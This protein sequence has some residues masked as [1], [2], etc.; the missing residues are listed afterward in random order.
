MPTT[1][2][3]ALPAAAFALPG[4]RYPIHDEAHARA[5]LRMRSHATPA[6]RKQIEAKVYARYPSLRPQETEKTA[7]RKQ[8]QQQREP[9]GRTLLRMGPAAGAAAGLALRARGVGA[10]GGVRRLV[11]GAA[12]GASIGWLPQVA[13]EG[14]DGAR[15]LR[16]GLEKRATADLVGA[17]LRRM[18]A[19]R[20]GD[21]M[22][23]FHHQAGD[24]AERTVRNTLLKEVPGTKGVNLL[25]KARNE[26]LAGWA[27]KAAKVTVQD[28]ELA[29]AI[30]L[31]LPG[32]DFLGVGIKKGK[33][34]LRKRL[35]LAPPLEKTA[36][37]QLSPE[38]L[39]T[40]KNLSKKN[41]AKRPPM[42][43]LGKNGLDMSPGWD[44]T[45]EQINA[46]RARG[47]WKPLTKT[48]ERLPLEKLAAAAE[49]LRRAREASGLGAVP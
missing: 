43:T 17:L 28:P 8:Q 37:R 23:R 9:V 26:Q 16:A 32:S 47:E 44:T 1:A 12:A 6:E 7:E 2:R 5:A 3:D 42:S 15:V 34:V 46:A 41:A 19:R 33:D 48:A 27:G 40:L 38:M 30:A 22:I 39:A 18:G 49:R 10:P 4:R 36:I 13:A 25:S 31:P 24:A 21:A 20:A 45:Y 14:A 35:N 11:E 29:A